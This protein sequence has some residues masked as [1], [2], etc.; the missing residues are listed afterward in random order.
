[1]ITF[2]EL[3]EQFLGGSLSQ[4]MAGII[5]WAGL[6]PEARA[7]ITR[8]L[9]L[10]KSARYSATEFNPALIRWLSVTV[11][12]IFP[13]AWGGRIPPLTLPG[14]HKKLDNYVANRNKTT[15]D[16]PHVFVDIGCGF[17]PATTAD[18]A[19]KLADWDIYGVDSAFDAY[20]LYDPDGHYACFDQKGAFQYF[21]ALMNLSG[22]A[23]YA[24]PQH[25]RN[26]FNQL[27]E[28]L[29]PLLQNLNG[30]M[31][32]TVE[33]DGNRLIHNHIRDFETN[34]L[35]FIESD[36]GEL[37]LTP[38]QVIRCMNVLLYFAPETRKEMLTRAGKLLKDGGILIA[39]TNGL[40]VQFRYAVYLKATHGLSLDEFAFSFDNLGHIVF[41][42]FLSFHENDPEAQML[43][44][45][46]ATIRADTSF[47]PEFS[48]RQDELLKHYGL[49]QRRSDGFFQFPKEEITP[50]EYIKQISLLWQD[51][52]EEGYLDRAVNTLKQ[53]GYEAWKNSVGDIAIRPATGAS[54]SFL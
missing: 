37:Q 26:K 24:D 19:R 23:L 3:V 8:A 46:T 40:G 12:S 13:S 52:E 14:R 10:M 39:G 30:S 5:S 36:I 49:C 48:N 45:L 9:R 51:M 44:T 1:M 38:V 42:P 21:Q 32:E 34:N 4:Q 15:G 20:V 18:T 47:W 53:S 43:A 22:R 16:R 6:P 11:P 31:S 27:F 28:D 2:D 17:P 35:T 41:M 25:T 50:A 54:E 33:K 29:C 7:F